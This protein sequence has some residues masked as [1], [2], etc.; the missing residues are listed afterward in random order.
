VPEHRSDRE[1]NCKVKKLPQ[2]TAHADTQIRSQNNK[3]DQVKRDGPDGI[4]Q[5]LARRMDRVNN[6]QH[7]KP[8]FFVEK[9]DDRVEDRYERRKISG[10]VVQ[11]KIIDPAM[12]PIALRA[13]AKS[14]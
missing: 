3:E 2:A 5:G 1:I 11:A 14:H 6:V 4:V 8:S 10:S 7:S 12:R 13:V 9:E